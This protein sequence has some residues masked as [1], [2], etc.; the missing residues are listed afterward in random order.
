MRRSP[1]RLRTITVAATDG[2]GTEAADGSPDFTFT[3][4][5]TGDTSQALS[6]N[7]NVFSGGPNS[8][9]PGQDINTAYSGIVLFAAGSA[10]ATLTF[11]AI[12]DLQAE[13]TESF[14]VS[15]SPDL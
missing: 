6:V 9:F 14:T 12:N 1:E 10:T 4:T 11:D 2:T 5:R 7:Y 3:F 8:A 15:I 13:N